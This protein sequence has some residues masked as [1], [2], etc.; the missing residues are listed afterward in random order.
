MVGRTE[1]QD[2]LTFRVEL[3]SGVEPRSVVATLEGAIRDV[4]KLRGAV[5]V[6]STGTIP[7]TA[8]KITDTRT[9]D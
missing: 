2:T 3:A 8:K 6:V 4:M 1:H 7:E 5:E 9:W